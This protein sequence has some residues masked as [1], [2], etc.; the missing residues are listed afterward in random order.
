MEGIGSVGDGTRDL[1]AE[2]LR[3]LLFALSAALDGGWS[4][5]LQAEWD[6]VWRLLVLEEESLSARHAD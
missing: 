6:R 1:Q 5:E 2:G 3:E 4:R